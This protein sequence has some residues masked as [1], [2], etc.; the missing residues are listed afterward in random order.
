[1]ERHRLLSSQPPFEALLEQF[2]LRESCFRAESGGGIYGISIKISLM[3]IYYYYDQQFLSVL[4]YV[5]T[6]GDDINFPVEINNE[7]YRV[8]ANAQCLPLFPSQSYLF[9]L[10]LMRPFIQFIFIEIKVIT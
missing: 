1:M 8:R 10:K 9:P 7:G 2:N 5:N 6:R 4:Q 3:V